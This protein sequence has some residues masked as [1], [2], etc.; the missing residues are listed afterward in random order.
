MAETFELTDAMKAAIGV[1]SEPW[2]HEVTTTSVRAFARGVG[3]TDPVF[4]DIE[5]ARA[6]GYNNLP[7]P[8]SYLGTPVFQPARSD[9]VFSGPRGTGPGGGLQ[10]GL[11]NVLDGGTETFY[12][13]TP[14]AGDVLMATSK[15]ANLEV[16]ES[17][18]LG[19]MLVIT[20]E[21]TFRDQDSGDV[22]ARTRGQAIYY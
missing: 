20:I 19:K 22:V 18:N 13:R 1:E 14:V 17:K 15:L 21:G 16:K 2:I 10:H 4:Y 11:K 7:A 8:P 12:E 9:S 3:Y 5:V 6:A